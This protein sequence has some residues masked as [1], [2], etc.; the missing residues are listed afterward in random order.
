MEKYPH[1]EGQQATMRLQLIVCKVLQREAYLCARPPDGTHAVA[2]RTP[3]SN[4]SPSAV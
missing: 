1:A 2:K 4:P 3:A